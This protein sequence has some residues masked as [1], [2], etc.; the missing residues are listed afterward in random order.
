MARNYIAVPFEYLEEMAELTDEEF[1]H[2]IRGLLRY[3]MDGEAIEPVGNE[4]FYVKR[5]MAREDRYQEQFQR[6]SQRCS[7]A[8]KKG[9]EKRWGNRAVTE[10]NITNTD[11]DSEAKTKT[12]T[13]NSSPYARE[14]E[15]VVG[16]C[17]KR[18]LEWLER[19]TREN[20]A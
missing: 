5:A 7:E 18:D 16:E 1:G 19:F 2:L 11:T 15:G 8:G 20:G 10:D 4:R 17:M 6:S 13:K 12:K 14:R 3:S 9:M